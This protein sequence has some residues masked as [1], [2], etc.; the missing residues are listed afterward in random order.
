MERILNRIATK[1]ETVKEFIPKPEIKSMKGAEIGIISYGSN[2]PAICEARD[3]LKTSGIPTDYLRIKALPFTA[4][5]RRFIAKHEKNYVVEL[6][7]DGQMWQLLTIEFPDLATRL[8]K[9]AHV[10]GLPITARWIQ[11]KIVGKKG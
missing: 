9:T 5:A 7:R 2:D 8:I 1:F 10:D 11:E 6:N 3:M 4:E